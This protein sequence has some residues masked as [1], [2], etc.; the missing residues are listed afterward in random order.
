M[1]LLGITI[2]TTL[3]GS[4]ASALVPCHQFL[5][6]VE[7][8][9]KELMS[10]DIPADSFSHAVFRELGAVEEPKPG[11]VARILLPLLLEVKPGRIPEPNT[12][13]SSTSSS[14]MKVLVQN[15]F[16]ENSIFCG[17]MLSIHIVF[18]SLIVI[19]MQI[20]TKFLRHP[21]L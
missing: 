16:W 2:F 17:S 1:S 6:S 18:F 19:V 13:V 9:Q 15:N 5:A 21:V 8:L 10:A 7:E 20:N 14:P 3:T 11:T 4:N 12:N